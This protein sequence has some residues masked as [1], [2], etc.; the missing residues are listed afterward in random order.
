MVDT[1]Q[2][3]AM[4]PMR[5]IR[6]LPPDALPADITSPTARRAL[7][8]IGLPP[9]L[10]NV[11]LISSE[12][13]SSIPNLAAIYARYGKE[14]APQIANLYK[15]ATFGAGSACL[16]G[17]NGKVLLVVLDRPNLSPP[18]LNTSLVHF[19][20]FIY[21]IERTREEATS[22]N[23]QEIISHLTE[24]LAEIDPPAINDLSP[25]H[26]VIEATLKGK[27]D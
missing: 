11:V 2:L 27:D 24:R 25:W 3:K 6:L 21:E 8:E 23:L 13:P 15:I 10:L 22:G 14:S 17:R 20:E 19:I 4:F 26:F 9:G 16:D 18:L 1:E 12:I 7:T 5:K